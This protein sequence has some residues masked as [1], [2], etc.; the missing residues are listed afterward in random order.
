MYQDLSMRHDW[1]DKKA[2]SDLPIKMKGNSK[3]TSGNSLSPLE[4]QNKDIGAASQTL[5]GTFR[6][7]D[8]KDYEYEIWFK[9]FS[10]FAK[11]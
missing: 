8:E 7:E 11:N 9:V 1:P 2:I 5:L 4:A 6:L 3:L 10:R